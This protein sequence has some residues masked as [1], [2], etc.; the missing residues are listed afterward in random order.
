MRESGAA[1]VEPQWRPFSDLGTLRVRGP[2]RAT[3][4]NGLVTCDVC[5]VRS[6]HA[7]WG[8]A[9][10]RKGKIQSVL[11]V[12]AAGDELLVATSAGT[13]GHVWAEFDRMLIMEDAELE[14]AT[15][16]VAWGLG[17]DLPQTV[18]A[19]LAR[20]ELCLGSLRAEV[21]AL[22]RGQLPK[23]QPMPHVMSDE[24]WLQRRLLH[25]L[26]E[27]G[28][29][30][31]SKERPHEAGLER[32]AVNWNKGCYLGQEVVCMQ[33]MRG[34]VSRQLTALRIEADT[35]AGLSPGGAIADEAGKDLGTLTSV[36]FV[37]GQGAWLALAMLPVAGR[38]GALHLSSGGQRYPASVWQ[39]DAVTG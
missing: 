3:W 6:G 5:Q 32:R 35:A 17:W 21:V 18:E 13:G 29:D 22:E 15:E 28:V 11:W 25:G 16:Q 19:L 34:K 31:D 27:F 12:V 10:D 30:F 24:Q 4:L 36:A 33:D 39:R 9:L 26:P 8:L 23:C 20:G 1:Q 38:E 37:S 2:E 14:D 7:E